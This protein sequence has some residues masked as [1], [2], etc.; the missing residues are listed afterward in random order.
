MLV[1]SAVLLLFASCALGAGA[2][3]QEPAAD[4]QIVQAVSPLPEA[5]RAGAAV[6]GYRGG[7]LVTL[8]EG[9]NAMVCVADDPA[10]AG[11]HA[12]CYHRDLEPFMARGRELRAA[13]HQRPA[14]DSVRQAEI[15]SGALAMPLEPRA[16]YSLTSEREFDPASGAAPETRGLYVIYV[17][18]ATEQSSGISAVPARDRPWLMFPGTPWAHVMIS[19]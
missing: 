9:T 12:A 14:V 2:H 3:S 13:G 18:Y 7:H 17:P 4:I 5:M 15:E 6:L 16:L 11:F 10:R 1:R 19:R 8:R